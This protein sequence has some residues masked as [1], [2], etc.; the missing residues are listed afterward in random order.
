MSSRL[1][2]FSFFQSSNG[3]FVNEVLVKQDQKQLKKNDLIG[4]GCK[5]GIADQKINYFVY[6]LL[7]ETADEVVCLTD[8][9][10][11]ADKKGENEAEAST[12]NL[13][14]AQRGNF[15]H[16]K[17]ADRFKMGASSR[18]DPV[19]AKENIGE[20]TAA[21]NEIEEEILY[22]QQYL[23]DVKREVASGTEDQ[24]FHD[25][26]AIQVIDDEIVDLC[27]DDD[28]NDSLSESD[29]A[30]V[31]RLSQNQDKLERIKSKIAQYESKTAKVIDSLPMPNSK[32][33]KNEDNATRSL[34][35]GLSRESL[36][37]IRKRRLSEIFPPKENLAAASA[38]K[39]KTT[40]KPKVKLAQS[41]GSFL[42]EPIDIK[43]R[44]LSKA[45]ADRERIESRRKSVGDAIDTSAS[46]TSR[47]VKSGVPLHASIQNSLAKELREVDFCV[48]SKQQKQRSSLVK[49][50][51]DSSS[52]RPA[53]QSSSPGAADH[54]V[55]PQNPDKKRKAAKRVRFKPDS[56]LVQMRYFKR[57]LEEDDQVL[58][59]VSTKPVPKTQRRSSNFQADPLHNIIS[60]V[61][62]WNP[63][64]LSKG[65][66]NP[67]LIDENAVL[68]PLLS[69]YSSYQ[70]FQK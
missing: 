1:S 44:R 27:Y 13:T 11:D 37:R 15:I 47:L 23:S 45:D 70:V 42:Q 53:I 69:Q 16:P 14:M 29:Q 25:D 62:L 3:T 48:S 5:L 35:S 49:A 22:S 7:Q 2:H 12:S 10:N 54:F 52:K 66:K 8:D 6:K 61:T 20:L 30:W 50:N 41:R 32:K 65:E 68:T 38:S 33:R 40:T 57:D 64:W 67:P 24:S 34:G 56:E 55:A 51:E 59:V 39:E 63:D 18:K 17:V 43:K 4:I 36:S 31:R 19:E 26:D 28:D 46:S 9:D 21:D 60:E 58:V